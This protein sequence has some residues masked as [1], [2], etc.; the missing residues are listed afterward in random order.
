MEISEIIEILVVA[1]TGITII[2]GLAVFFG[3]YL[4]AYAVFR[5]FRIKLS[6]SNY[7]KLFISVIIDGIDF[8]FALPGADIPWDIFLGL[9]GLA[10]WGK[11]WKDWRGYLQA[12][13]II[14]WPFD[15]FAPLMT[16]SGILHI[17]RYERRA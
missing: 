14:P 9:L 2:M 8:F 16:L 5:M 7:I 10:L 15:G 4:L 3:G 17:S 11:G 12:L 1:F 13:E 6:F